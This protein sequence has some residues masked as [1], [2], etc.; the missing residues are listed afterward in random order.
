MKLEEQRIEIWDPTSYDLEGVFKHIERCG[1]I[2]YNS[3]MNSTSFKDFVQKMINSKHF[4]MLEH[5]TIYLKLPGGILGD[6]LSYEKKYKNNN[7]SKCIRKLHFKGIIPI[8]TLYVTTNLRVIHEND[9]YQDLEYLCPPTKYHEK[10]LTCYINTNRV[11]GESILRH[12]VFSFAKQSTRYC[13]YTNKSKYPKGIT[14][15]KPNWCTLDSGEYSKEIYEEFITSGILNNKDV[16]IKDTYFL[17]E[18]FKNETTYNYLLKE[19]KLKPEEA[20]DILNFSI[21]SPMVMTGFIEDWKQF[22]NIRVKGT[23]G[24][25][26]PLIKELFVPLIDLSIT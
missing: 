26:H 8:N 5:G 22:I 23:T 15:I 7:Y 18:C 9:W 2:C 20:R 12:R 4:S 13:N 21:S 1:R 19:L 25:P 6:I 10:R 14:Y 24:R 11:T 3:K 17:N 16:N